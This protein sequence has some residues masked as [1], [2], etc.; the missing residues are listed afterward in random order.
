MNIFYLVSVGIAEEFASG[1][2][3]CK[4]QNTINER[5]DWKQGN[6]FQKF[7]KCNWN[8]VGID[9]EFWF[10]FWFLFYRS[11]KCYGIN[12]VSWLS[13]QIKMGIWFANSSMISCES[14]KFLLTCTFQ[15]AFWHHWIF[16]HLAKC[17]ILINCFTV[18]KKKH[19]YSFPSVNTH[20][21][22]I[23]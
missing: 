12:I 13:H 17:Q 4:R 7:F 2:V 5:T 22:T 23:K 11:R 1:K 20:S 9:F 6:L 16:L 10:R 15:F 8:F 3:K 14:K 18:Q 19:W 21:V